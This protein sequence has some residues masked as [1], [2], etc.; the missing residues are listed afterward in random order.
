VRILGVDPVIEGIAR[1]VDDNGALIV[2][3]DGQR[4]HL[5][6]G[7]VSLRLRGTSA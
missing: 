7:E 2:E 6:A 5:H 3:A 4:H 1:G